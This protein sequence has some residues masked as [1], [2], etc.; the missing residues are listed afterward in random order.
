[1]A[2]QADLATDYGTITGAYIRVVSF[3]GDKAA[4]SFS[5][6]GYVSQEAREVGM[7]PLLSA[8]WKMDY[9]AGNLLAA[10]YDLIKTTDFPGAIDV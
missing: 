7:K 6:E 1:M 3:S 9:P 4:I 8:S 5:V 2:I 10:A